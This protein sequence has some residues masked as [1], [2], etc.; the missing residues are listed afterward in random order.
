[1]TASMAARSYEFPSEATTGSIILSTAGAVYGGK[2]GHVGVARGAELRT[3]LCLCP[4]VRHLVVGVE[5]PVGVADELQSG[6]VVV[7]QPVADVQVEQLGGQ[8]RAA[9]DALHR[10]TDGRHVGRVGDQLFKADPDSAHRH[11]DVCP[12]TQT[13]DGKGGG[14][15]LDCTFVHAVHTEPHR[16]ASNS[17]I[18][19]TMG[20]RRP[21]FTVTKV[22]LSRK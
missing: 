1:M 22:K 7:L 21:A 9:V 10:P 14:V 8:Q 4:T 5:Q 13:V 18:L 12:P 17:T 15:R 16:A 2:R 11:A 3:G 20:K 19:L 6:P